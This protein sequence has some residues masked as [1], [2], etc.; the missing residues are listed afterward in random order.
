MLNDTVLH[1]YGIQYQFCVN[2]LQRLHF[3]SNIAP[4]KLTVIGFKGSFYGPSTERGN[5]NFFIKWINTKI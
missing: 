5:V 4:T 1:A 3:Y 2:R